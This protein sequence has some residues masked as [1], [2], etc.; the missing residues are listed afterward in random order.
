MSV[1]FLGSTQE[2]MDGSTYAVD[3]RSVC[4]HW[5]GGAFY[6]ALKKQDLENALAVSSWE[7]RRGVGGEGSHPA[8]VFTHFNP[9]LWAAAALQTE[10]LPFIFHADGGQCRCGI[11]MCSSEVTR[12]CHKCHL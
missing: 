6:L 11:C 7:A 8:V 12:N 4:M 1:G 2:G 3:A 10:A 5:G 9:G